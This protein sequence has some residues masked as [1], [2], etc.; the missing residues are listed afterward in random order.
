MECDEFI[1][2]IFTKIYEVLK[3][4]RK[5]SN[6]GGSKELE[7]LSNEEILCLFIEKQEMLG[8]LINLFFW[9]FSDENNKISDEKLELFNQI[10]DSCDEYRFS[11]QIFSKLVGERNVI[12]FQQIANF[13]I[14]TTTLALKVMNKS[15]N[16]T[17]ISK[18][19][20]MLELLNQNSTKL[21]KYIA[22]TYNG[23][24]SDSV[25]KETFARCL[26]NPECCNKI[27]D[28]ICSEI[29]SPIFKP[30]LFESNINKYSST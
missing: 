2:H 30:N 19:D 21:G 26:Y 8:M 3:F 17:G 20:E 5:L 18:T 10:L 12:S 29:W 4:W 7:K 15:L 11:L 27:T 22:S 9:A 16:D 23:V 1:K 13:C 24:E 6:L 28:F 14:T 25:S